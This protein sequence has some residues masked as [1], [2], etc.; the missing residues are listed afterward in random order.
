MSDE[1]L[2]ID[3]DG[4]VARFALARGP[5]NADLHQQRS[6]ASRD[7][8]TA[9]DCILN[10][11]RE[12]GIALRGMTTALVL[13]G[14][15]TGDTVRVARC[16]WIISIQG[17][18]YVIDG[19]PA[20]M[21]DSAAKLWSDLTPSMNR[22]HPIGGGA[23]A[24]QLPDGSKGGYFVLN[25]DTGVG[26]ALLVRSSHGMTHVETE[27]GHVAFAPTGETECALLQALSTG[28]GPVAWERA[29]VL[30]PSDP[31][32]TKTP[33]KGNSQEIART[34]AGMLGAF[35]G[36]AVLATGAWNGLLLHGACNEILSTAS[37]ITAF[38][39]RLESRAAY[40]TL[41]RRVPRWRVETRE[42]NLVGAANFLRAQKRAAQ[43]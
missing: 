43:H 20:V 2:L 1:W 39:E 27:I 6:Y 38:N 22:H 18:A 14:A 36:D 13:S 32:W 26:G 3:I 21:N 8:P 23:G 28:R 33:A 7:F 9:T 25:C 4:E 15:I 40:A 19:V 16:P 35:C 34:R 29:L 31:A 37:M 12:A 5:A 41:L 30:P 17:L 24:A 11:A 10:Y 42:E